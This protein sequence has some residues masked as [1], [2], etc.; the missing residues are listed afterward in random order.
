M[1]K[2]VIQIQNTVTLVY[3][4]DLQSGRL[5]NSLWYR[6]NSNIMNTDIANFT[7]III[8]ISYSCLGKVVI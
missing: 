2:C 3:T 8:I 6:Q 1:K 5:K 7:A 4:T